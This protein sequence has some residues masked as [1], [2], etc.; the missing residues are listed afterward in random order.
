MVRCAKRAVMI[1]WS[2]FW[3][4]ASV[5]SEF[6]CR[7][8]RPRLIASA[9]RRMAA[10]WPAAVATARLGFGTRSG[11]APA[12]LGNQDGMVRALAWSPDGRSV[13]S[14]AGDGSINIWDIPS[15]G[16][17]RK[18]LGHSLKVEGIAFLP[19]HGLLMSG[20]NDG[21]VRVWDPE[22]GLE[23]AHYVSHGPT[24]RSI[25]AA[26]DARLFATA[27]SD[28]SI[29]GPRAGFAIRHLIA[30]SSGPRTSTA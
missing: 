26:P 5:P 7:G 11:K 30:H 1:I 27:S 18:L 24:V 23:V 29:E 3:M 8:I 16:L 19:A 12:V 14:G 10:L 9:S 2:T 13:A 21:T 25:A 17:R 28:G 15:W 4:F 20:S 22:A 6:C